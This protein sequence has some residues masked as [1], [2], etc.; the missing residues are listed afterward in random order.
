MRHRGY[1]ARYAP[2]R[3][4]FTLVEV[5]VVLGVISI[6]IALLLPAIQGARE[7]A[8]RAQCQ[9][10]LHQIGLGIHSYHDANNCFPPA[11]LNATTSTVPRHISYS[12]MYSP[13]VRILPFMELRPLYD[14][15]NFATGTDPPETLG[16]PRPSQS[17]LA[18][19][20]VNSTVSSLSIHTFI[21]PSDG[22]AF[23]ETGCNYRGNAGVGCCFATSAEFP[24]SGNGLFPEA[25]VVSTAWVPD[26]LSHTTAFS[27]RLRG[28][29]RPGP[30]STE[31][32]FW[33]LRVMTLT[34]DDLL[35]GCQISAR[36]DNATG[37]FVWAGRWWFWS[38]RERTLYNHAQ[39]PNGRVPDCLDALVVGA[40]GMATARSWHLGGVNALMG[41]GSVRFV[42][43]SID[44]NVWRALGTRNGGELV[45]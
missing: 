9:N 34:A 30:L 17:D 8:R 29:G 33:R 10:N 5:L 4:A 25:V 37:G 18:M 39:P 45:D 1:A 32:D 42:L 28:S 23:A 14:A 20:A 27:E 6:L 35:Q 7:A 41:D 11:M 13:L 36:A 24:D 3:R 21:C 2:Q 19:I 44:T 16:L 26:G 43:D 31:R 22:G 15:V 38:G 12:G 40:S